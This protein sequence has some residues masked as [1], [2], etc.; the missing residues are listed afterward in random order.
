[1]EESHWK[2]MGVRL[3]KV[4]Y[5]AAFLCTAWF[6][7]LL[8]AGVVGVIDMNFQHMHEDEIALIAALLSPL[9]IARVGLYVVA[10]R[11]LI[12]WRWL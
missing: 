11:P 7:L 12:G 3:W 6:L 5:T 2:S 9:L 10:G 1:M 8:M 4:V